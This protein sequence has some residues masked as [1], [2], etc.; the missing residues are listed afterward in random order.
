[1]TITLRVFGLAT[2]TD[3]NE[4]TFS[5]NYTVLVSDIECTVIDSCWLYYF[6]FKILFIEYSSVQLFV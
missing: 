2:S 4:L 1:M 3:V 6:G 5:T